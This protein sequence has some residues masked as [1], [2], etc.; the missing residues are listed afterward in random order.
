MLL[1]HRSPVF[2]LSLIR[3]YRSRL[4]LAC[5]LHVSSSE[6][7]ARRHCEYS[8]IVLM[9]F[10]FRARPETKVGGLDPASMEAACSRHALMMNPTHRA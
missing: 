8:D 7:T 4:I 10:D 9:S 3:R 2:G 1:E 5:S 6:I